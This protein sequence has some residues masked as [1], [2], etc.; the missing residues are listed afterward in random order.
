MELL[1]YVRKLWL[2][3]NSKGEWHPKTGPAIY[4]EELADDHLMRIPHFIWR[5]LGYN[6]RK[7]AWLHIPAPIQAEIEERNMYIDYDNQCAVKYKE[8]PEKQTASKFKS[9]PKKTR[10]NIIFK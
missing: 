6:S 7:R 4:V 10:N 5:G 3:Q 9:T 8:E 1:S 2:R